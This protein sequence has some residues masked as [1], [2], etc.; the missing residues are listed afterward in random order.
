M[1]TFQ[2]ILNLLFILVLCGV[3][4]GSHSYQY[5]KSEA[6]CPLCLL[7]RLGM[8]G[9]TLALLMNLRFGIK[10]QHYALAIL[11]ALLGRLVSLRQISFH[12]CPA[13]HSFGEPVFGF[14]LYVW[15]FLVFT[16]SIFACAILLIIYG[17]SQNHDSSPTWGL[18]EKLISIL[19][20]L[21]LLG[22][23]FTAY[24]DCG[25]T[26]CYTETT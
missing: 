22:N 5:L 15:A 8:I 14:D 9:I 17:F 18:F 16:A 10:V 19:I 23:I 21:I 6:P 13:L 26:A 20:A 3:L 25:L 12:V 7:Q 4:L 11:S 2:R 1:A 24:I